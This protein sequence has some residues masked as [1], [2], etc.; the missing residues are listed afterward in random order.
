VVLKL[1]RA[2]TQIKVA[3]RSYYPQ[4][5]AVT[6]HDTDQ[7]CGFVSALPP[8]ELHITPGVEFTPILGT[9]GIDYCVFSF[10]S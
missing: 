4:Y 1:F 2:V 5:F 9:T 8:E 7:N 10:V 3:I 6:A